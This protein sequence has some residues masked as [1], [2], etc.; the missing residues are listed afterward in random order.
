MP[1]PPQPARKASHTPTPMPDQPIA[2]EGEDHR[3]ARVVEPAQHAR[4]DDLRAVDDLED[5][6]DAE[7]RHAKRDDVGVGGAVVEEQGD[8]L[9][10]EAAR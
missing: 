3:H 8:Q 6:G 4:A 5:G 10:R 1:T 2:D 7:E 9:A